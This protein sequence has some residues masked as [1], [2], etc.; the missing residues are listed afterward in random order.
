MEEDS[1][2][3]TSEDT[4]AW[5]LLDDVTRG[6]ATRDK[7][8][9]LARTV[10]P[11]VARHVRARDGYRCSVPGCNNTRWLDNHHLDWRQNGGDNSKENLALTCTRHHRMLH[12]KQ[13]FV[14]PTPAGLIWRD[15]HGR[16]LRG[17][18]PQV[19]A[20]SEQR[21]RDDAEQPECKMVNIPA[22]DGADTNSADSAVDELP[23]TLSSQLTSDQPVW[24]PSG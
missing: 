22:D 13:L 21:V 4:S 11:S 6:I 20:E 18:A 3:E 23:T 16:I 8:A 17:S 7:A 12:N 2:E 14:T 10:A 1:S 9:R 24:S 5:E 15:A 19:A